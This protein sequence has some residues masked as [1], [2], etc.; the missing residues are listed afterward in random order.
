[1]SAGRPVFF[2]GISVYLQQH[3]ALF[4]HTPWLLDRLW[5]APAVIRRFASALDPGRSADARRA[6]RVDAARRERL[7]SARKSKSCVHWL[8]DAAAAGRRQPAELDADRVWPRRFGALLD[9]PIVV[10][11]QGDDLFLDGLTEPYKSQS[12][13]LIRQQV[14][15]VDLF[16]SVSEYYTGYMADYLRIPRSRMRTVPL[17]VNAKDFRPGPAAARAPATVHDR[18]PGARRAGEG[19]AQSGRGV[20]HPAPGARAAAVAAASR[21]ATWA[22]ISRRISTGIER[23][24]TTGACATSSNT[25]ARSIATPKIAFPAVASTCSRCPAAIT[26]PR[27]VSA[28]SD[29]DRRARSS[30]PITARFRRCSIE[31]AAAC[32]RRRSGRTTS[33][34]RSWRCGATRRGRQRW[35]HAAP[36]ASAAHY[37]IDADGRRPC[38]RST[39]ELV[40]RSSTACSRWDRARSKQLTK[41]Y[42]HPAAR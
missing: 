40:G 25:A 35:A 17:G 30:S 22:P 4:R 18:L 33:R 14:A 34:T 32:S 38:S 20:S 3:L 28:R 23:W 1:M 24:L 13:D 37:T 15:D 26:S 21:R 29:G 12:I 19:A 6:D 11:L 9:R 36:Q 39:G 2:G 8:A 41:T 42:D 27:A 16:V 7:S 31:P 5:D 10:T